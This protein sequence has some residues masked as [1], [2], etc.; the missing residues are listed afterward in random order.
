MEDVKPNEKEMISEVTILFKAKI[1]HKKTMNAFELLSKETEFL[2]EPKSAN[3]CVIDLKLKSMG[4]A[5][6]KLTWNAEE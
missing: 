6:D 3:G 5:S 4:E 2:A 1:I